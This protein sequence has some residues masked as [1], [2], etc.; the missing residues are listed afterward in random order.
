MTRI[1]YGSML[2]RTMISFFLSMFY[3]QS[4]TVSPWQGVYNDFFFSLSL[5]SSIKHLDRE[6]YH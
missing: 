2:S 1:K 5:D 6:G 3:H 4:K